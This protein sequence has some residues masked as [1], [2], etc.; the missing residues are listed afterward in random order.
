MSSKSFR[1]RNA[2]LEPGKYKESGPFSTVKMILPEKSNL[3]QVNLSL[4]P[5]VILLLL[6]L[7]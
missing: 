7:F 2:Y 1:V 3:P 6:L 5:F 4:C